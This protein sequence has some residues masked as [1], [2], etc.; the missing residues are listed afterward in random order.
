MF[1]L[2]QFYAEILLERLDA[3]IESKLY[4]ERGKMDLIKK[5]EILL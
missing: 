3:L 5:P 1:R 4:D 2:C